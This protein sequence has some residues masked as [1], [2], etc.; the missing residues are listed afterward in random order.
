MNLTIATK[1]GFVRPRRGLA[2]LIAL[3]CLVVIASIM[4]WIVR[5]AI[6]ERQALE[7]AQWRAQAQWL[8]QSGLERAAARLAGDGNFSGETWIIPAAEFDRRQG[9]RV[10]IEV[11]TTAAHPGARQ[12]RVTAF[13]PDRLNDRAQASRR[14]LV[15][16][17]P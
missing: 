15:T 3:V 2:L 16:G 10:T 1:A 14:A 17:S 6:L 11:Q 13:Y 7:S 8:A 12:V 4:G 5:A 9:G